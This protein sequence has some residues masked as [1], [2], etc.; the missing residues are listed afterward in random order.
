[1]RSILLSLAARSFASRA[2]AADACV[3]VDVSPGGGTRTLGSRFDPALGFGRGDDEDGDLEGTPRP[4]VLGFRSGVE[5]AMLGSAATLDPETA[6]R[7]LADD[8][9][10][11][12]L[13]VGVLGFAV[14]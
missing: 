13:L 1:M 7:V 4:V 6:L 5:D 11:V 12:V 3:I 9:G 2:A 14:A 10:F 8:D